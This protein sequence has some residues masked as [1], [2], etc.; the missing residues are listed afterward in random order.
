MEQ[1]WLIYDGT[2]PVEDDTSWYLVVK[3]GT[4]C[5]MMVLGQYRSV[6]LV[7]T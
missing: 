3:G 5:C 2:R 1:D 7:D 6:Q 4:G